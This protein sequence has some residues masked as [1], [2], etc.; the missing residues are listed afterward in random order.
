MQPVQ[1]CH[2]NANNNL[3]QFLKVL[4]GISKFLHTCSVICCM[5]FPKTRNLQ[6]ATLQ[7]EDITLASFYHVFAEQILHFLMA[8]PFTFHLVEHK[9]FHESHVYPVNG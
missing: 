7:F 2:I 9:L 1:I 3:Q 8:T 6:S 4:P 5:V